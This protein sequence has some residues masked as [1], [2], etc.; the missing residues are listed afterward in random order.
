[1]Q[2]YIM[3]WQN[4]R[5]GKGQIVQIYTQEFRKRALILAVDLTFQ[6]NLLKYIGGFHSY[7]RH[8]ILIFNPTILDE[9]FV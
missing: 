1:M 3:D 9:V 2:K 6:G 7:L 8:T 5:Q 4:F